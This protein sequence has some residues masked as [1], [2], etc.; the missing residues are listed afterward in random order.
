[1]ESPL[2]I[3]ALAKGAVEAPSGDNA[4]P[5]RFRLEHSALTV[6]NQ[7]GADQTLYNF[8]ERGSYLAHGALAENLRLLGAAEGAS[9]DIRPFPGE[10]NATARIT[11]VMNGAQ[12]DPLVEAI[13]AR[14]TNRKPYE[15][16][17]LDPA[18]REALEAA[19]R[20]IDGIRLVLA[21]GAHVAALANHICLNERLLMENKDLH[22]FLF[23]MIRWTRNEEQAKAGLYVK[24]MEFPL[25]LRMM[26]RYVLV[27]WNAVNALNRVGLSKNVSAQTKALYTASSAIGAF[28]IPSEN[29]A[30]FFNAGRAFQRLWLAATQAGLSLQPLAALP[31]LA[32]RLR[33]GEAQMFSPEHRALIA[34][35]NRGITGILGLP[36]HACIAMLFRTGYGKPPTARSAKLPPIFIQ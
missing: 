10:P 31:Y 29:D 1:M 30:D 16:K 36:E 27:H 12:R 25:P 21:H 3:Q 7:T 23:G 32:Q 18:H 8:R 11:F 4:Q 17:G 13:P 9:A 20:G 34:E 26:L 6:F 22:D 15:K 33:A 5:W 28:V 14:A 24:T 19:G 35:A 2:D